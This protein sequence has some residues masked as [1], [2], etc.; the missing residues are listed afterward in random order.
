MRLPV[1]FYL[2][3]SEEYW[4]GRT[5][6][7]LFISRRRL[8]RKANMPQA[9]GPWAL[10]SGGFTELT[11]FG[12][13]RTGPRQ[14]VEEVRRYR[15]EIGH[16]DWAAQQ[17][18]MCEPFMLEKTGLTVLQHQQRTVDNYLELRSLDP[19][20]PII[21]VLQGYTV[22]EYWR[23][24]AMFQR[25]GADLSGVVGIGS[26][27]RRPREAEIGALVAELGASFKLHGFGVKTP[28]IRHFGQHLQSADSMAWSY[29]ARFLDP[30]MEGHSHAR[31]NNCLPYALRW[32]DKLL[33]AIPVEPK[34]RN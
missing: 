4:L 10:D 20:L 2:G 9:S 15:K 1:K 19:S 21:P 11:K 28:A 3:T 27:C 26:L 34:G 7:P 5:E 6:V 18:W 17:D 25:N 33:A 12:E 23:H 24:V 16:L 32:R 13:W 22:K 29:Q 31:C 8:A 14:Y 30:P